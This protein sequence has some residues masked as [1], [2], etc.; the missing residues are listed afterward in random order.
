VQVREA[1]L[2]QLHEV[3][4]IPVASTTCRVVAGEGRGINYLGW[5]ANLQ[6]S[7]GVS[8]EFKQR[9]AQMI[10]ELAAGLAEAASKLTQAP[11]TAL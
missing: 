9:L 5:S 4:K 3:T 7:F 2:A 1:K 8:N 10:Q 6:N 11:A